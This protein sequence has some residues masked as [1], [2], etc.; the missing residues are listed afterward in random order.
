MLAVMVPFMQSCNTK[1]D[2]ASTTILATVR[3][4]VGKYGFMCILD[5]Q[6]T[7][8]VTNLRCNYKPT[9]GDRIIAYC[10][11]KEN[12]AGLGYSYSADIY[13]VV[14]IV[15]SEVVTLSN[16]NDDKYGNDGI[17]ILNA[18][19]SGGYLNL[20]FQVYL[21]HTQ[22]ADCILTL[23]NNTIDGN[24]NDGSNNYFELELRNTSNLDKELSHS[25]A[26]G[27]A[28]FR[29]GEFNPEREGLTGGVKLI[30]T[31]IDSK[32]ESKT[33]MFAKIEYPEIDTEW[34]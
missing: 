18:W 31:D 34:F 7:V 8:E 4:D 11:L 13:Q 28:C 1:G 15:T 2:S 24:K 22:N 21:N 9:V 23:L 26:Y 14:E 27:L 29:L 19:V 6:Q 17:K 16:A 5:N 33:S 32:N 25:L 10:D 12:T 30:Y 3:S 20:E